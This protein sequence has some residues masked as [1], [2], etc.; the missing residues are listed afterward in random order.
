MMSQSL[1][2][3]PAEHLFYTQR[4][5]I[6]SEGRIVLQLQK[7]RDQNAYMVL[8]QRQPNKPYTL[9]GEQPQT[10]SHPQDVQPLVIT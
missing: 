4:S 10:A 5:P 9:I 6:L 7:Y 1:L 3:N 8:N 2:T